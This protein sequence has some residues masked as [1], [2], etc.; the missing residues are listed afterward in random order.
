MKANEPE[1]EEEIEEQKQPGES[2]SGGSDRDS[3][4][5]D[6]DDDDEGYSDEDASDDEMADLPSQ[7]EMK[8]D[9]ILAIQEEMK[10]RDQLRRENE[11]LQKQILAMDSTFE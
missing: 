10:E 6:E 2:K 5:S 11:D 9:L 8:R 7:N 1:E 4:A 3:D